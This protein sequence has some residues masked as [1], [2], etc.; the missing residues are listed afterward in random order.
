MQERS[1][2]PSSLRKH[3]LWQFQMRWRPKVSE[4]VVRACRDAEGSG[5]VLVNTKVTLWIFR[6]SN[7]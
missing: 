6:I 3:V 5:N 2:L 1:N 7:H 4:C